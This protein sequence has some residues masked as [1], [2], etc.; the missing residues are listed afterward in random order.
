MAPPDYPPELTRR[1]WGH[2]ADRGRYGADDAILD[3]FD[4]LE[5][6][7]HRMVREAQIPTAVTTH[8]QMQ[9]LRRFLGNRLEPMIKIA[10]RITNLVVRA[11]LK[12]LHRQTGG[13]LAEIKR[14][15]NRIIDL[16]AAA[17]GTKKT[18]LNSLA[19]MVEHCHEADLTFRR[20][21]ARPNVD[22]FSN[23][24][25]HVRRYGRIVERIYSPEFAFF[26][27]EIEK[28]LGQDSALWIG[29]FWDFLQPNTLNLQRRVNEMRE[30]HGDDLPADKAFDHLIAPCRKHGDLISHFHHAL[31]SLARLSA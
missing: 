17:D 25:G 21:C 10:V 14:L 7:H 22:N 20:V 12:D 6:A 8:S 1:Y 30:K 15:A 19:A 13:Y 26:R 29:P 5:T 2:R 16:V 31:E 28:I 24:Q 11:E 3:L 4:G 27:D 9:A 23:F 18:L